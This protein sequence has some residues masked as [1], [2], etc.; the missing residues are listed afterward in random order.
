MISGL[1]QRQRS[2]ELMD[3]PDLDPSQHCQ[4]LRSLARTNCWGSTRQH[5]WRAIECLARK[6]HLTELKILDVASGAGD[7]AR[8]LAR[9]GVARGLNLTVEGC[10][11]SDVAVEFATSRAIAAG[12]PNVSFFQCDICASMPSERYDLVTCS[13]F[14]HH[15][16]EHQAVDLLRKMDQLARH[17]VFVDDLDRSVAGYLLAWWG[18]RLLT[19]SPIVHVDGPLSVRAAFT[20]REV[21][22][23][24]QEAGLQEVR[25]TRHWPQRYLLD[26]EKPWT[27]TR[28]SS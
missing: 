25:F 15:L 22:A 14:L 4:A 21:L 23:L 26:W 13:L 7:L 27:A 16:D 6:R 9:T 11:V 1:E 19:R 10:D 2:N 5:M 20:E 18:A 3:Q 28:A 8:W 17:G 12:S 24:T